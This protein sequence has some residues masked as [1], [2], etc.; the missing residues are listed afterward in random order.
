MD[1]HTRMHT[2]RQTDQPIRVNDHAD[3]NRRK[4]CCCCGCGCCC[5]AVSFPF[6][7]L[8]KRS[9]TKHTTVERVFFD[10]VVVD[11]AYFL[12]FLSVILVR[13]AV[14]RVQFSYSQKRIESTFI[15]MVFFSLSTISVQLNSMEPSKQNFK[16]IV[17]V[18]SVWYVF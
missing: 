3:R 15:V 16:V 1:K 9:Q 18:Q 7:L 4:K 6:R 8:K 14:L 13:T 17:F 12:E 11:V 5:F 10:L 2:Q